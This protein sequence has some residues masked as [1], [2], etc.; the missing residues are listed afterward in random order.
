[1]AAIQMFS[2]KRLIYLLIALLTTSLFLLWGNYEEFQVLPEPPY[3]SRTGSQKQTHLVEIQIFPEINDTEIND[4]NSHASAT[5]SKMS[6][7]ESKVVY[8]L[9][10]T[11]SLKIVLFDQRN[12]PKTRGGD[13][14]IVWMRDKSKGAASAGTVIDHDN[15]TY[16][17]V[18]RILWTGH[19]VIRAA[20]LSSREKL[21][22]VYR[23]LNNGYT[24]KRI[25]CLFNVNNLTETTS[26]YMDNRFLKMGEICNLTDKHYGVPLY[27]SKPKK[28]GIQCSNWTGVTAE[29]ILPFPARPNTKWYLS[30]AGPGI[31]PGNVTVTVPSATNT[32][33]TSQIPCS[34]T[35]FKTTWLSKP[36]GFFYNS[37]WNPLSCIN[38]ITVKDYDRCLANRTLRMFGDSTVRQ[39][40]SFL[41]KH[42]N[43]TWRVG[44]WQTAANFVPTDKWYSY[45]EAYK[46]SFN[47]TV[48]WSPH[49]L[50]M[51][52]VNA[53][54]TAIRPSFVH[55]DEIPSG[56]RDIVLINLYAHFHFFPIHIFRSQVKRIRQAIERLLIRSPDVKIVMKG[57]H[58]FVV[59]RVVTTFGR[60]WGPVYDKFIRQEFVDLYDNVIYLDLWDMLI[61][62]ES[63]G[64]HPGEQILNTMLR[65]LFGYVCTK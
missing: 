4:I 30:S 64:V 11:I 20:I 48:F 14:L 51:T 43:L 1:M 36:V 19:A 7:V 59:D 16:T 33:M 62:V 28:K 52:F 49:G 46:T 10:E 35:T 21:A 24:G 22:F 9:N 54:R 29:K 31:L 56:S 6:L 34:R 13:M 26:G 15:G 25:E 8:A 39:L 3:R 42:L 47:Y 12:R 58:Y 37:T 60:M 65:T 61:S 32:S 57:P 5:T 23:E 45:S 18:L 44:P 41:I 40:F 55:L 38:N 17:G 63:T 50:P 2:T 27:C 53:N